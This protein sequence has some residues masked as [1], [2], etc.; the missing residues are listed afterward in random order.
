M[1]VIE[2]SKHIKTTRKMLIFIAVFAGILGIIVFLMRQKSADLAMF[3]T[4]I[5]TLLIAFSVVLIVREFIRIKNLYT[6]GKEYKGIITVKSPVSD[7]GGS[8]YIF[9]YEEDGEYKSCQI[10]TG[11]MTSDMD[12]KEVI[13]LIYKKAACIKAVKY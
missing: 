1:H 2:K 6:Y 13:A 10:N 12:K 5:F 7:D 9:E 4:G 11:Y 8:T 3:L